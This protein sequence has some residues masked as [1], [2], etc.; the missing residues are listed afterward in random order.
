MER[1]GIPESGE[2]RYI[3]KIKELDMIW[4]LNEQIMSFRDMG[5]LLQSI[6]KGALDVMEATSGSLMLIDPPGSDTLVI[7]AAHGLRRD[8]VDKARTRVGEGIAG[9]VAERREG[10][11]L[12]DDLMDPRL[13]TRRKVSDAL[14]VPIIAEGELLGVLNLNTKRGQAFGEFDL[15]LLNTLIKQIA[16]AIVRGERLEELRSK[17][18]GIEEKERVVVEE[19]KRLDRLLDEKRREY[20]RLRQEH[21]RLLREM[22]GLTGP[23]A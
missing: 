3:R 23:V 4:R 11:L 13:R 16:T 10:M 22:Q 6:L 7:K 18:S 15:F 19:I 17:L 1:A 2:E 21:E 12:L 8:V 9:L 5:S 20:Q 14:S